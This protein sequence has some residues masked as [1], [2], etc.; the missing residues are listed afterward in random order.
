[1][2]SLATKHES[3]W[4]RLIWATLQLLCM[5][6]WTNSVLIQTFPNVSAL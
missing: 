6:H 5:R 3:N 2:R 1:M 4:C